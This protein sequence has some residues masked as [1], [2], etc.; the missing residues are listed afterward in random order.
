MNRFEFVFLCVIILVHTCISGEIHDAALTGDLEEIETLITD[1]PSVVHDKDENNDTPLHIAAREGFL[2]VA[3]LLV[4]KGADIHAGDNENSTPLDVAAGCGQREM[5]ELLVEA[6]TDLNHIDTNGNTALHFSIFGNNAEIATYLI[7]HGADIRAT[8]NQLMTP[9]IAAAFR[10]NGEI[11]QILLN[12]G[13]D[14]NEA[15]EN[16]LTPL[17]MVAGLGYL[18][19]VIALIEHGAHVNAVDGFQTTPLLR[20]AQSGNPDIIKLLI[21]EGADINVKD[22]DGFTPLHTTVMRGHLDAAKLLIENNA[23]TKAVDSHF[24]RGVLHTAALKG[25]TDIVDLLI[26][27][28]TDLESEDGFGRSAV[29]LAARY[30]N[31]E[32]AGLLAASGA[33][34]SDVVENYEPPLPLKKAVDTSDAVLWYLGHCGWGIKTRNH[35][36]VFDYFSEGELP[37]KP[38]LING[39]IDPAELVNEN[40]LVFVTHEHRDHYDTE[41]FHWKEIIPSITYIYGFRPEDLPQHRESGYCGPVYEYVGPRESRT[42]D[43]VSVRTIR[44]NDAGVGYLVEVDG[45]TI[46]HAGDHAGWNEGEKQGFTDEIDYLSGISDKL[47][48]AF[49]N[50]TGCHAHGEIPLKEGT[51]Y[52]VDR[53]KPKVLVPTH[54]GGREFIYGQF[55]ESIEDQLQGTRFIIP[56]N[57]GDSYYYKDGSVKRGFTGRI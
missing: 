42:F 37:E 23:D 2:S 21:S 14:P 20:A 44:A 27:S 18:D 45:L 16:G 22:R 31:K 15:N 29:E 34:M 8:N 54:A 1:N 13:V 32:V 9:L 11:I 38:S 17:I 43:D 30:G 41:I 46:Y 48:I 57:R 10:R 3:K 26:K 49:C 55:L 52:T 6:G 25:Y 24:K 35:F 40:V 50:V 5:V 4:E 51:I 36:L 39:C 12:S 28:D 47:D 53:L 7:D 19:P 56:E 33:D